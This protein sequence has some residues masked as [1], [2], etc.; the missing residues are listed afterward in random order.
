[1]PN[2]TVHYFIVKPTPVPVFDAHTGDAAD[3]NE[4]D[5][6]SAQAARAVVIRLYEQYLTEHFEACMPSGWTA[7]VNRLMPQAGAPQFPDFSGLSI[8]WR[9]PIVYWVSQETGDQPAD[10]TNPNRRPSLFLIR[11]L[12]QGHYEDFPN[13]LL[14]QARSFIRQTSGTD[15]GGKALSFGWAPLLA[16]VFSTVMVPYDDVSPRD[17]GSLG[18]QRHQARSL[19]NL[20]FHEIAHGK[21]EWTNRPS[22]WSPSPISDSVHDHSQG[23][24]LGSGVGHDTMQTDADRSLMRSHVLCPMPYYRLGVPAAD[25]CYEENHALTLMSSGGGGGGT[26]GSSAEQGDPLDDMD[27]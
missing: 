23:G 6:A 11:E 24:I 12:E 21:C 8:H 19:A 15:R 20:S 3:L 5:D 4:G 25:Q 18:W 14:S 2:F 17:D 1:M 16:E 7:H 10:S 9:E 26:T 27:I 13:S 22:N